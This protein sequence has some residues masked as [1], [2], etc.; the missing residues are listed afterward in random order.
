MS[1]ST[2]QYVNMSFEKGWIWQR[3]ERD[4]LHLTF[5]VLMIPQDSELKICSAV[6]LSVLNPA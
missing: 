6:L 1:L 2:Q 3:Q 5:A 4:G